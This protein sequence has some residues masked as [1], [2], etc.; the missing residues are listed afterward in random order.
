MNGTNDLTLNRKV[1]HVAMHAH[2]LLAY[3]QASTRVPV[4]V[5]QIIHN[6]PAMT[7]RADKL[8]AALRRMLDIAFVE[9]TFA[10]IHFADDGIHLSTKGKSRLAE[11][12]VGEW[13]Q[14]RASPLKFQ[15][16]ARGKLLESG[17]TTIHSRNSSP[18][19]RRAFASRAR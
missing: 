10:P 11:F 9:R 5:H 18:R 6:R 8:N 17:G 3:L 16:I 15:K 1:E 2:R 7:S 14:P 19:H 4:V 13:P 12:I